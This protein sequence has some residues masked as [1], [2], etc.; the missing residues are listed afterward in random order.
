MRAVIRI[1]GTSTACLLVLALPSPAAGAPK[2]YP[3]V[4][5]GG[6]GMKAEF[7]HV[8]SGSFHSSS[9]LI[10][11]K[12]SPSA[13]SDSEPA[14]G[15]CAWVDRPLRAEEPSRLAYSPGSGQDFGFSFEGD[16]WR[17]GRTEDE[18]LEYLLRAILRPEKF[19][20][21]CHRENGWFKVDA[22]GP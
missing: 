1:L 16:R 17:P 10:T 13:A 5:K 6:G 22:V 18:R 9:L 12:K 19:Y 14:P 7:S 20:V 15:H 2:S 3:M 8:K 4:C 21:R 11:I